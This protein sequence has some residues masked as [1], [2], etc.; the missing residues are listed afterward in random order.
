[1]THAIT[2]DSDDNRLFRDYD[3]CP[4]ANSVNKAF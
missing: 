4:K 1:M 2:A 3:Y